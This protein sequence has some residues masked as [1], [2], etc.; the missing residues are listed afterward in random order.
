[1]AGGLTWERHE[2]GEDRQGSAPAPDPA[3]DRP[4][5]VDRSERSGRHRW[6]GERILVWFSRFCRLTVRYERCA[7][8]HEAFLTFAASVICWSYIVRL[9]W[10]TS[11]SSRALS[12]LRSPRE[13]ICRGVTACGLSPVEPS[14][15]LSV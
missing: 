1:M 9:P 10:L 12:C 6:I 11:C 5:R 3:S 2:L 14:R 7:D 15:R 8:N 13:R 4:I